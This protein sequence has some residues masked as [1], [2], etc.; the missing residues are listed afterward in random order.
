LTSAFGVLLLCFFL[1]GATALVYEVVWLRMLGLVFGHTVY[2]LTTV[3]AAFMAGLGLGSVLFGRRAAGFRDPIRVYGILEVA[4]GVA[5][6]L[7]PV[8]IWLASLLYPGLQGLLSVSYE[9]F[10]FVQFLLVFAILLV[11]TTLMGGT[12]PILSQALVRDER[13]IGRTVGA[14][15]AVNT[16]GAVAGA[17]LAGY[18]LLPAVGNR[19][20]LAVAV[21]ANLAVGAVA[22][23]YS[24]RWSAAAAPG[25]AVESRAAR[26]RAGVPSTPAA[27]AAA[28]G[29]GAAAEAPA[30]P[31][32]GAWLTLGAL[33]LSGAVSMVYEVAWTRA[34]PR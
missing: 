17:M 7:T 31:D 8:L 24:R 33:G 2:A 9:A 19:W 25:Q 28:T 27:A 1:S 34:L 15:Y 32:L 23:A 26:R 22:I 16:F 5:C 30:A 18:A 3:L 10:S 12:L 13:L 21:V 14:L 6:G 11:P 29:A 4:I 20:T